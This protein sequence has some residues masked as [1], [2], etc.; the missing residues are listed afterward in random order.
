MQLTQGQ[1]GSELV[2]YSLSGEL[3]LK[4]A[5]KVENSFLA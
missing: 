5:R 2:E 1:K 3:F 4:F